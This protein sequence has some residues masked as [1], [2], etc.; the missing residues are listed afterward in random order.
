MSGDWD[1]WKIFFP[2]SSTRHVIHEVGVLG[3]QPQA[4]APARVLT[5]A[6][7]HPEGQL[8]QHLPANH[9][10]VCHPACLTPRACGCRWVSSWA[11]ML[12]WGEAVGTGLRQRPVPLCHTVSKRKQEGS[13]LGPFL[14]DFL[15]NHCRQTAECSVWVIAAPR[16]FQGQVFSVL[17]GSLLLMI[18]LWVSWTRKRSGVP[19]L[20]SIHWLSSSAEPTIPFTH[21]VLLSKCLALEKSNKVEACLLI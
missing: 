8:L 18:Y 7:D 14:S 21:F 19:A 20:L 6:S 16:L 10:L 15:N 1:F 17:Q 12:C 5:H 2:L 3:I 4:S 9:S 13:R 11:R